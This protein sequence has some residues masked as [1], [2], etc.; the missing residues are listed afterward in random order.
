MGS[1]RTFLRLAR[2]LALGG[3]VATL[4]C[5]ETSR[6]H[7]AA[8]AGAAN[9]EGGT[10]G[11]V[12]AMGGAAAAAG[13]TQVGP[14]V[15]QDPEVAELVRFQILQ[16][17]KLDGAV[18]GSVG[19]EAITSLD[20]SQDVGALGGIECLKNLEELRLTVYG[21]DAPSVELAPLSG[22]SR[23]RNLWLNGP[24]LLNGS[25]GNLALENLELVGL[26]LDDLAEVGAEHGIR[27]LWLTDVPITSLHGI[28]SLDQLSQLHVENAKLTS[29]EPLAAISGLEEL[30]LQ[31]MSDLT[32][33]TGL[34]PHTR[35][36]QVGIDDIPL[37]SL[38]PLA[39]AAQ[40]EALHVQ[41]AAL[42]SLAGLEKKPRL[43]T[44][45]VAM[46]SV[47]DVTGL[48]DSPALTYL[49][50][51]E[52]HIADL[53]PL[54][55][56]PALTTLNVNSN[57]LTSLA[58]LA[59]LDALGSLD[60]GLNALGAIDVELPA[61]LVELALDHNAITSIEPLAQR[62]IT[63]LNISDNPLESLAPLW[64]L[65]ALRSL[66]AEGVGATT[67]EAFPLA[68]LSSLDAGHNLIKDVAPLD[69]L[70][71]LSVNVSDNVIVSLPADF[72][73]S[74]AACDGLILF[75]NP[76]D[77]AAHQRLT[78]LCENGTGTYRWD[79][80]MCDKCPRL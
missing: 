44:V 40:L 16:A 72:V 11:D 34:E 67:L 41:R 60:A 61:S 47:E 73:G 77:L 62:A 79:G 63:T 53:S 2:G 25:F 64:E 28:E 5:G 37:Q 51:T 46:S 32:S 43:T 6:N 57:A 35:L 23:L 59:S 27:G 14:C 71:N 49:T 22:L 55:G 80:G 70:Q 75:G 3:L 54:A 12:S 33:L 9:A 45:T 56:C 26:A 66:G 21:G 50:L 36:R 18:D 19:I 74:G 8:P 48:G 10:A 38:G 42:T 65:P 52:N 24:F 31:E 78:W 20:V 1:H 29:L 30:S 69:G 13:D 76:L 7:A 17:D 68:Q 4:G 15:F 39:G 58:A